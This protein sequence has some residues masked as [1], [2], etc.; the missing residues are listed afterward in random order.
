VRKHWTTFQNCPKFIAAVKA[1]NFK[2]NKTSW[3]NYMKNNNCN[4]PVQV[5]TSK[6]ETSSKEK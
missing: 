4:K 1:E 6:K 2:K 5:E 3:L